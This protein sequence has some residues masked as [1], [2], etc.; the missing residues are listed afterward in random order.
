MWFV[1]NDRNNFNSQCF[2]CLYDCIMF[3]IIIPDTPS[4]ENITIL[5]HR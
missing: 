3:N 4:P 1:E 5:E 2:F